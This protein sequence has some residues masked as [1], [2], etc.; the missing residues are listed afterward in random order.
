MAPN[1]PGLPLAY[2][3]RSGRDD[4]CVSASN[5]DAFHWLATPSA[6]PMPRSVLIGPKASG[7][8]HLAAVFAAEHAATIIDD[9]DEIADGESLFHAW[10]AATFAAPLLLTATRLP[11]AWAHRLPDLAS[12]L[13]ATPLVRIDDPDDAL[14]AAV[15]EKRFADR[16]L[17][18]PAEVVAYLVTRIERSFS[19]VAVAVAALDTMSLAERRDITV[20][21]AREVLDRQLPLPL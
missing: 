18:V 12:R 3:Q 15:L 21:L 9:A 16:G 14:L 7:K 10:N 11:R 4:F 19:A 5:S 6:W 2:R 17:R 1:Q 8:T 13:A 20:P